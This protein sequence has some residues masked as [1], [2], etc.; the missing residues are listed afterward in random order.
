[1]EMT[2]SYKPI[3]LV[4]DDNPTNLQVLLDALKAAGLKILVARSGES[5]LQQAEYAQPDL[6]LLDVMMP[7]I[8]G[9]ETCR[10]LKA[11]ATLKDIPVI[12][13]TALTDTA[14]KITGFQ[15]GGVDFIT[16]PLQHE[17][18]LA[19]VTTHL[20]ICNLQ[21]QL[22]QQNLR[23]QEKNTQ[24][25]E[26]NASKDKF[27]AIIA[28]DLRSPLAT[29]LIG[30]RMLT[31]E[32]S[33]LPESERNGILQ[34]V[35]Q[36]TEVLHALIGN[37]LTWARLQRGMMEHQPQVVNLATLVAQNLALFHTN[38]Q[39]KAITMHDRIPHPCMVYADPNMM[40]TIIRNLISN[41]LKFTNAQGQ[42]TLAATVQ[43]PLIEITVADTGIGMNA[44][45]LANLFRLDVRYNQ[46]GTAGEKGTGLGLNL[47]QELIVKNDG[48]IWVE[49]QVGHGTTFHFTLPAAPEQTV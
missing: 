38:A 19:R 44:D 49:S 28:H 47:C 36:T 43:T 22:Q 31:T 37:L 1:M 18:V 26:L 15:V 34:D 25:A 13:M 24:L 4:V 27:F 48:R 5:A 42:I 9:F 45:T 10:R 33:D 14:D 12:F 40:D 2:A 20:T 6:I 30:L 17:E 11:H 29:V 46:R 23:L 7:G 32:V 21:R 8:D 16:K 3:V 41:A 39:H 35:L